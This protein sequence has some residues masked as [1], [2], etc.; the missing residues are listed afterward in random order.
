LGRR[1]EGGTNEGGCSVSGLPAGDDA[2]AG[3]YFV[4]EQ[5]AGSSEQYRMRKVII[6]K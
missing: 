6:A 5:A 3:V 1:A 2:G 4:M